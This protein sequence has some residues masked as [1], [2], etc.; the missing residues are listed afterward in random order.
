MLLALVFSV[1]AIA[2][3]PCLVRDAAVNL[4]RAP[5][6]AAPVVYRLPFGATCERLEVQD[7]W[8]KLRLA[9]GDEG[10]VSA[11]L[12]GAP[13]KSSETPTVEDPWAANASWHAEFICSEESPQCRTARQ[14]RN[15]LEPWVHSRRGG[16][17]SARHR[18]LLWYAAFAPPPKNG[19]TEGVWDPLATGARPYADTPSAVLES[20]GLLETTGRVTHPRPPTLTGLPAMKVGEALSDALVWFDV[21]AQG[22]ASASGHH[23]LTVAAELLDHATRHK[24]KA[25]LDPDT[26]LLTIEGVQL[27]H[28]GA[29]KTRGLE[30]T[31]RVSLTT[32]RPEIVAGSKLSAGIVALVPRRMRDWEGG[33]TK[34]EA[35]MSAYFPGMVAQDPAMGWRFVGETGTILAVDIGD[36]GSTDAL[37]VTWVMVG[38]DQTRTHAAVLLPQIDVEGKA[39]RWVVRTR[40][41]V[42]EIPF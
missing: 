25:K 30:A 21:D 7:G 6:A 13:A 27:V 1:V 32:M 14:M 28:V 4:R 41:L 17:V 12:V 18:L 36:N 29:T 39:E 2:A 40:D 34:L 42:D 35:H 15:V 9:S 20:A 11:K 26:A 33:V 22:R 3:E 38:G 23:I 8:V 10:W 16:E 19:A 31:I 5:K 24:L 37:A